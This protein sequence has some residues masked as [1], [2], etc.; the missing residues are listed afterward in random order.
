MAFELC[1]GNEGK[2]YFH[3]SYL[4][5][6]SAVS[7]SQERGTRGNA[8]AS[9]YAKCMYICAKC[10][11]DQ[12]HK[13]SLSIILA[14][15]FLLFGPVL[16]PG[17]RT[18]R[19]KTKYFSPLPNVSLHLQDGSATRRTRVLARRFARRLFIRKIRYRTR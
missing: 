7:D 14:T 19:A 2:L 13:R 17:R 8:K 6:H 15:T 1:D 4:V 9:S 5:A 18:I 11:C 10:R 3:P 16:A 12:S